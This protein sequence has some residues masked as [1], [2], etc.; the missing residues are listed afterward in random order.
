MCQAYEG[1]RQYMVTQELREIRETWNKHIS[2][3]KPLTDEQVKEL[4]IRKLM[5]EEQ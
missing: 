4:A 2:G 5:L 1:E 3:E